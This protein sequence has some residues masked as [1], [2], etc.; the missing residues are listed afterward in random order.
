MVTGASTADAALVLVDA[1]NGIVEQSRRHAYIAS[2]LGIRHLIA[3][4]NKMDLVDWDEERFREIETELRRDRRAA[5]RSPTRARS[6]SRRSRATTSST[7]SEHAPW[8]DGEP[9]LAQLE[10]LEVAEDRN[11]DDVRFPVQW[12]IRDTRLPRLRRPGRRRRAA[13]GR[14]GASCCRRAS[15]RRSSAST[16]RAGRSRRPSRRCRSTHAC[17]P[18]T[19]DVGRGDMIAGADDAPAVARHLE[20]TVC[21]MAEAPLRA[22]ARYELKHTTRRVRATIERDRSRVDMRDARRR[23][24]RR[25]SSSSTTSAACALR[26][27]APLLADPYAATA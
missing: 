10:Q 21:W 8:Y 18:T 2:L 4:V 23:R 17:S 15:A 16:R 14:R 7:R 20:A 1:R 26:T 12:T 22:G 9:L 13:P 27:T 11:L 25:P 3:C 24:A 5:R 6:R 19:L